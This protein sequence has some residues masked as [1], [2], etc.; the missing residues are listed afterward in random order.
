MVPADSFPEYERESSTANL[1]KD[2]VHSLD[3]GEPPR[4]GVRCAYASTELIFGI[5]E[6]HLN[7]GARIPLPLENS[8]V[9][10]D[11]SPSARQPRVK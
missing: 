2:L 8:K 9:R 7:N 5:I 1:I 10:L 11:R 6:S 3:T 4:G